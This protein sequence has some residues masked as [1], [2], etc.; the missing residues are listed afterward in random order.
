MLYGAPG[1]RHRGDYS[2]DTIDDTAFLGGVDRRIQS[3]DFRG[4]QATAFMGGINLDLRDAHTTQDE[5]VVEATAILGGVKI[6]N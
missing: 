3:D 4:G 2:A 5:V 1:L 6:R